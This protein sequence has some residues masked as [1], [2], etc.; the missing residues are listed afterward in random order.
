MSNLLKYNSVVVKNQDTLVIDSNRMINEILEQQ[1]ELQTKSYA[2]KATEPDEDGFVCGIDAATVEQLVSD[3]DALESEPVDNSALLSETYKEQEEILARAREE[4]DAIREEARQQGYNDGFAQGMAEADRQ[5]EEAK[6]NS[7]S[8]YENKI[9]ELEA[10]YTQKKAEMEPQLVETLLEVFSK[11]THVM[12]EDKK[13]MILSL[14]DGVMRNSELSREFLIRVSEDDYKYLEAN[15]NM[16][17]GATS[18]EIHI[19]ICRDSQ[20]E[21]NQCIIETDAGVFDCSLDIQ[22]ENLIK[23]IR[24]LSCMNS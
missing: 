5:I 7:V 23:D 21:R 24:L 20:L 9:N 2:A 1:K 13:D 18:S 17:Y 15:K 22:L 6:N 16:L 14:V 10:E 19:D 12:A 8:E 4:A 11:V 3:T